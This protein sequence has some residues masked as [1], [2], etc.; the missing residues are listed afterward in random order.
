MGLSIVQ[1]VVE[2]H[3]GEVEYRTSE[4]LGG[5]CFAFTIPGCV[6]E[7]EKVKESRSTLDQKTPAQFVARVDPKLRPSGYVSRS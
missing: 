3:G 2:S 4:R 1:A 6:V 7:T 5:A